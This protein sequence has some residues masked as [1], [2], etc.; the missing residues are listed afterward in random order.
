[1]VDPLQPLDAPLQIADPVHLAGEV[2]HRL[3]GEHLAG[4]CQRAEPGRHVEG[5]AAIAP[6]DRHSLPGVE[7]N[8]NAARHVLAFERGL[9]RERGPERVRADSNTTNA[10]SP[11][12]SIS[13][14]S[15]DLTVVLTSSA[16]VDANLAAASSPCCWV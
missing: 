8:A 5:A 4:I 3:A 16:K 14:P 9:H 6:S 7:A 15:C 2:N 10:S 13:R 11:R 12:S 1:M